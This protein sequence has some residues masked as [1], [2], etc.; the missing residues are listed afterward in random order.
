MQYD[1]FLPHPLH[2]T[3]SRFIR[4]IC[5]QCDAYLLNR[6]WGCRK[7]LRNSLHEPNVSAV[8]RIPLSKSGPLRSIPTVPLLQ[9]LYIVYRNN[10]TTL[11]TSLSEFVVASQGL[12]TWETVRDC[13]SFGLH[14]D[15][16]PRVTLHRPTLRVEQG[17]Y[18]AIALVHNR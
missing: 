13:R 8:L 1:I 17:S 12:N 5:L 11:P 9:E 3:V 4:S 16:T 15:S 6:F 10:S 2:Y 14:I 18:Q 7:R